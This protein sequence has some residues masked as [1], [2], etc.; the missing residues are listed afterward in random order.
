MDI[1]R[2]DYS[3][4]PPAT[5][6][7][8]K[9]LRDPP[10]MWVGF[11]RR[12]TDMATA[13]TRVGVGHYE[14]SV[15]QAVKYDESAEHGT[16]EWRKVG[17]ADAWAHYDRRLAVANRL[18]D[19]EC[20]LQPICKRPLWPRILTWPDHLVAYAESYL[21]NDDQRPWSDD[22]ERAGMFPAEREL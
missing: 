22:H 8:F 19:L 16:E 4:P 20:G 15:S 10:G 6:E 2:F 7:E 3:A 1:E 9:Q 5:W 13:D 12:L 14:L 17:R 11:N 18:D 21:V